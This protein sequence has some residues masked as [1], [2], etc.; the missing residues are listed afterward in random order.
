[1][2]RGGRTTKIHSIVAD[3]DLPISRC[4]SPG[5]SADDPVGRQLLEQVPEAIR[6]DKPLLLDKAYEGNACRAK[7]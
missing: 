7:A 1:M 4:V 6:K 2:S 5:S 3:V